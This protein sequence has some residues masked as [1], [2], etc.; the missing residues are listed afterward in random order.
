MTVNVGTIDRLVR[1]I[2]G[3]ALLALVF[4]GPQSL[5]GL[6]GL[7]PLA[8]A[9]LGYCP[10]YTLLGIKTCQTRSGR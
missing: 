8:T 10:A 5:W 7:V 3:V 2:L 9:L 4:F 6:I 1:I